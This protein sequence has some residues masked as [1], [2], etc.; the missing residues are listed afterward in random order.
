M[1]DM[2]GV[3][4]PDAAGGPDV[5]ISGLEDYERLTLLGRGG[6]ATVYSARRRSDGAAVAV[7]VFDEPDSS[8]FDRQLR[9]SERLGDID[10]VLAILS[11]VE[12]PDRRRCLVL[13]FAPGGSLADRMGEF[14]P[15]KTLLSG[16]GSSV[17][18]VCPASAAQAVGAAMQAAFSAEGIPSEA[19]NLCADNTGAVI[20]A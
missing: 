11:E 6:T 5:P 1:D 3:Q 18:C 12:L 17:L 2:A 13:P 14:K 15:V 7:K 16:S 20:E 9:A 8:A 4:D 19:R 10:G